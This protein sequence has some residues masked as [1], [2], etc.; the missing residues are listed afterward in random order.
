MLS[1]FIDN[2]G[3]VDFVLSLTDGISSNRHFVCAVISRSCRLSHSRFIVVQ[4]NLNFIGTLIPS[5][6]LDIDSHIQWLVIGY[7]IG[8][9]H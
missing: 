8:S 6:G 1:F 9:V 7:G 2:G 5:S 4:A 3:S